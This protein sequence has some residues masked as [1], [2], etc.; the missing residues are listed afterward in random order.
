MQ[1]LLNFVTEW[2]STGIYNFFTAAFASFMEW[3]ILGSLEMKLWLLKFAWGTARVVLANLGVS[4]L[5]QQAWGQF[6]GDTAST[7]MFFRIPEGLNMIL[8]AFTTRFV[9][10][11]LP[12]W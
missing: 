7:L 8:S 2:F 11:F 12:G 9:L 6:D 3:L 1:D 10:K 5:L 4:N